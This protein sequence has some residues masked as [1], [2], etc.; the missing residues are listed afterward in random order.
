VIRHP[1]LGELLAEK[2]KHPKKFGF[3]RACLH[4]SVGINLIFGQ[5]IIASLG[6]IVAFLQR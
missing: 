2:Q 1:F 6:Q 3:H 4:V 5:K